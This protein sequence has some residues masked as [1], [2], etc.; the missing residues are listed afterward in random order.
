MASTNIQGK[1]AN[2]ESNV[3]LPPPL[4][5]NSSVINHANVSHHQ[6]GRSRPISSSGRIL[7]ANPRS[8]HHAIISVSAGGLSARERSRSHS[9]TET[10]SIETKR[11]SSSR[12]IKRRRFDDELVESSLGVSGSP[13]SKMARLRNPSIS[14]P[15][16]A[17]DPARRRLST[18]KSSTGVGSLGGSSGARRSRRGPRHGA[19][20]SHGVATRDLGRWKPTDDLALIVGVQQMNDLR[21][22]HRAVKF[23]CRFTVAEIQARWYALLYDATV[24]RLAVAAM[25]NLHPETV[26]AV[27]ARAPYSRAEEELLGTI[28]SVE[29]GVKFSYSRLLGGFH[30]QNG[31]F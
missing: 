27:R 10:D 31:F 12:S 21:L 3:L 13:A 18:S 24:S 7:S 17:P 20:G 16:G 6:Q 25:R 1:T 19:H 28:K 14:S 23:S 29:T 15:G 22:V 5:G 11:R 2:G 30:N 26:A 4:P 9:L 8:R